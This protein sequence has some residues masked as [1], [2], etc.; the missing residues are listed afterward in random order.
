VG[1][2]TV[3]LWANLGGRHRE[4]SESFIVY[5]RHLMYRVYFENGAIHVLVYNSSGGVPGILVRINGVEFKTDESGTVSYAVDK[6]GTYAVVLDLDGKIVTTFVEVKR[7]FISYRQEN[8]TLL[9]KVVDSNGDPVPNVTL[10]ASGPLGQEYTVTGPGGIAKIDLGRVGYG[11]VLLS[12][13]SDRYI[14]ARTVATVVPPS[15]P[16]STSS[17]SSSSPIPSPTYPNT[18][19]PAVPPRSGRN[20][21]PLILITSGLILAGTAYVAFTRPII[22]EETLDRH[23]FVKVRAPRLKPLTGF[24]FEKPV[25]AVDAHA[26]KGNVRLE[27][28]KLIWELDLEPG[29]EAYLQALLG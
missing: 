23:Y 15:T 2:Y 29:E 7:L 10:V 6:P 19:L 26:T 1:N 3:R 9:V 27:N 5:Q 14:G 28:G 21:L 4:V 24:R 12:A 11:S 17:G 22:H 8:Q 18:T 25:T 20:A 16:S 13:E